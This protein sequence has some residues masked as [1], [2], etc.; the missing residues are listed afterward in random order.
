MV[1]QRVFTCALLL[2][3][4][5]G[6][7][8]SVDTEANKKPAVATAAN[9]AEADMPAAS[10]INFGQPIRVSAEN[11][12]AAE[13]VVAAGRD[14]A[15]YVAWVEHRAGKEADVLFARVDRDGRP[16]G[17]PVRVN[18]TAGEATGWRGD[19]PTL[20]VASGG[21][22]YVGWTRRIPN[23]GAQGH[24]NDLCL[25]VSRD[26]GQTFEPPVKVND[27]TKPAVHGMHSLAIAPNGRIHL[28]WLDERNIAPPAAHGQSA[29]GGH[30]HMEANREVFTSYSADEGRT[31]ST[32]QQIARDVCPCCK[33]TLVT[34][35]DNRVYAS[36]RQVLPGDFRHIAVA[37]STD[38]GE[39]FSS[40]VIVSDDRWK[41]NGCPVS[42]AAMNVS[43]DG[44]LRV[45][46]Y[47]AGEAG[48]PGLYWS[49]SRDE[50]RTFAPRQFFAD[51]TVRGTPILL[52][53][54]EK[55][56]V[57]VWES[58]DGNKQARTMS[59]ELAFDGRLTANAILA[60]DGE[61]PAATHA[62][63]ALFVAYIAKQSDNRS[64]WLVRAKPIVQL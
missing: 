31:F 11:T 9:I 28:A 13:P 55:N 48:K 20:A 50:G 51:G 40:P 32:N 49:E 21:A 7:A 37:S 3:L 64:I 22:I 5:S 30:A 47:T 42:G 59:R 36:W 8:R 19:P 43:L 44:V 4:L 24:A 52:S 12:D 57:G 17:A 2:A 53:D 46:W 63:D 35:P 41:L 34:A 23:Q 16:S 38:G 60:S 33:T 61:L 56:L 27:D 39:S 25:S 10:S 14:G 45:V 15:A 1:K 54:Q 6:C 18:R 62:G 58:N 26:G 29:G